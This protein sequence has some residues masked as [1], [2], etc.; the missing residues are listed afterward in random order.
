MTL[1]DV[2]PLVP[3]TVTE[4]V[5]PGE[6][7]G[8]PQGVDVVEDTLNA[9]DLVSP[10][11]GVM[12]AG[13]VNTGQFDPGQVPVGPETTEVVKDTLL[14]NAPKLFTT[15]LPGAPATPRCTDTG[16]E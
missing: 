8:L 15:R 3:V 10:A 13:L 6:L 1:C 14:E 9:V 16:G 11:K 5:V 7:F 2:E 4:Y 12:L